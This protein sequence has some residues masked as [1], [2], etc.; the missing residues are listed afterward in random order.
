MN[1]IQRRKKLV[2]IMIYPDTKHMKQF[3]DTLIKCIYHCDHK[4]DKYKS[5]LTLENKKKCDFSDCLT[6]LKTKTLSWE[7]NYL[8][9]TKNACI[10][11]VNSINAHQDVFQPNVLDGY[12]IHQNGKEII[13]MER[14]T[15]NGYSIS[16]SIDLSKYRKS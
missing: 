14:A 13:H 16:G 15:N 2:N 1:D 9:P 6:K 5:D 12:S 8:P 7:Q 11:V 3:N 10:D 4:D